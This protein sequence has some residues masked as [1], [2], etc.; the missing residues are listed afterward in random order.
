M[1]EDNEKLIEAI[2]NAIEGK[3]LDD[4]ISALVF[5]LADSV[6]FATDYMYDEDNAENMQEMVLNVYKHCCTSTTNTVN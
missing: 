3:Q 2:S 4:V 6:A 1:D 5:T